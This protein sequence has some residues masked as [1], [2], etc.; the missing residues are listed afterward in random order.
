MFMRCYPDRITTKRIE[1][2]CGLEKLRELREAG[3]EGGA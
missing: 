2:K 1:A 3:P